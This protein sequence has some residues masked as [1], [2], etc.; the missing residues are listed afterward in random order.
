[1]NTE[2][3]W[4]RNQMHVGGFG[5]PPT[6]K[7]KELLYTE[8]RLAPCLGVHRTTLSRWR[9]RGWIGYI[10]AGRFVYYGESHIYKWLSQWVEGVG[11]FEQVYRM[12]WCMR[13]G[14]SPFSIHKAYKCLNPHLFFP[15]DVQ[16]F[17][18]NNPNAML[19]YDDETDKT[20]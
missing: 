3:E 6:T 18:H 8:K 13:C 17:I 20:Y 11:P 9:K 5:F 14:H 16:R 15:K 10:R 2:E 1:M 4:V 19:D 12:L 7:T